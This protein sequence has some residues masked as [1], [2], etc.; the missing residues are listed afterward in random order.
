ARPQAAL[1]SA[2]LVMNFFVLVGMRV[3]FA[4][5]ARLESNWV[6]RVAPSLQTARCRAAVRKVMLL[7]AA[8]ALAV[9]FP[10]HAFLW[11]S[12]AA[13]LHTLYS[14][15]LAALLGDVLLVLWNRVPFTCPWVPGRAN[16]KLLWVVYVTAF[17]TYAYALAR[18]EERLLDR[19]LWL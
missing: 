11:G 18:L 8:A 2:A 10:A 1:L 19:P 14:A 17:T 12:R 7:S 16:L 5:P 9:L 15:T 6:F 13:C 4:I 3:V